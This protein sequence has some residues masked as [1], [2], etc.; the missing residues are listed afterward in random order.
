MPKASAKPSSETKADGALKANPK[1][2]PA[3][4]LVPR[5]GITAMQLEASMLS[6]A[7]EIQRWDGKSF[8]SVQRLQE[9]V[10]NHGFVDKMKSS[11]ELGSR[12]VAV[13]RMPNDWVTA[14]PRVPEAIP[15]NL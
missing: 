12:L 11:E 1:V 10:R 9:A 8:T 3:D 7:S 13:K 4:E 14:G 2:Y 15:H 6:C 5:D